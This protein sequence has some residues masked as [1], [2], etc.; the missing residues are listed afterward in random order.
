MEI[1]QHQLNWH[2]CLHSRRPPKRPTHQHRARRCL[3]KNK[4]ETLKEKFT[5]LFE[6]DYDTA[7]LDVDDITNTVTF[8]IY[9]R[10]QDINLQLLRKTTE[11]LGWEF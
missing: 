9:N 8:T 10:W 11:E 7:S 6:E 1:Q 2:N 4:T 3:Q 5:R